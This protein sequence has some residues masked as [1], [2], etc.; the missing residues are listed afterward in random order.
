MLAAPLQRV[1]TSPCSPTPALSQ[2]QGPVALPRQACRSQISHNR[3]S[4]SVSCSATTAVAEEAAVKPSLNG[5]MPQRVAQQACAAGRLSDDCT[6]FL[7][8][9]RIRGYEVGPD[10]KTTIL[11][12]ANLLQVRPLSIFLA[13]SPMRSCSSHPCC[14]QEVAGNHAVAL[15]GRTDAGYATDPIMVERHLIFAATRIQ[16]R[17][18]HYPRWCARQPLCVVI[19]GIGDMYGADMRSRP[20][21]GA[22]SCR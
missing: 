17:M 2:R 7:E 20:V 5:E 14:W 18:E 4:G 1:G 12:M 16:I 10:Q 13:P 8:E 3:A 22:T 19:W 11:T 6:A 21:A 15:W 9:H